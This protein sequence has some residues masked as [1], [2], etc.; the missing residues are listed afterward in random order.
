MRYDKKKWLQVTTKSPAVLKMEYFLRSEAAKIISPLVLCCT[1]IVPAFYFARP[2]TRGAG[3]IAFQRKPLITSKLQL[4][5]F[6]IKA[7]QLNNHW[8]KKTLL[9]GNI[10]EFESVVF[11]ECEID[12][13]SI[14]LNKLTINRLLE[15]CIGL[16]DFQPEMTYI[17]KGKFIRTKKKAWLVA[18]IIEQMQF[19]CISWNDLKLKLGSELT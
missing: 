18:F 12:E 14:I 13:Y 2:L 6:I 8:K 9:F 10:V 1:K 15:L 3:Q 17:H 11:S 4:I 5:E 7:A 16:F 19:Y